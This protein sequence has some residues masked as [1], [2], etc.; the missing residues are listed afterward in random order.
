MKPPPSDTDIVDEIITALGLPLR[1]SQAEA[2]AEIE[3]SIEMLRREASAPFPNAPAVNKLAK[4][5]RQQLEPF[6]DGLQIPLEGCDQRSLTA[7][8]LSS[9]LDWLARIN[10]PSARV[11]RTKYLCAVLADGLVN[12]LAW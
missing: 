5:L 6:G 8:E 12:R 11:G 7:R 9:A 3:T 1:R 4:S 2:H 10:G